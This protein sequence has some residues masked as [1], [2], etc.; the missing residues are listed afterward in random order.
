MRAVRA[1]P[2]EAPAQRMPYD[3]PVLSAVEGL[4]QN[5][6]TQTERKYAVN[7]RAGVPRLWRLPYRVVQAFLPMPARVGSACHRLPQAP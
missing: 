6:F 2:V 3:K 7:V 1:E 4:K 5:G